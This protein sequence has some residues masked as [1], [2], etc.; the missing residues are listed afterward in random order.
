MW[1]LRLFN[2][3]MSKRPARIG[4]SFPNK[5]T[6]SP[7]SRPHRVQESSKAQAF[8]ADRRRPSLPNPKATCHRPALRSLVRL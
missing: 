8:R 7:R 2:G 4:L 5:I 3:S 1:K 6:A